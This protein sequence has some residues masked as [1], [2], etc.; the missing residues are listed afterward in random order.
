MSMLLEH[1]FPIGWKLFLREWVPALPGL[2]SWQSSQPQ[3]WGKF[4]G[5]K[6]KRHWGKHLTWNSA[7]CTELPYSCPKLRGARAKCYNIHRCL[8]SSSRTSQIYTHRR[9]VLSNLTPLND[10][11]G[12]EIQRDKWLAQGISPYCKR[13]LLCFWLLIY[14]MRLFTSPSSTM[15]ACIL[16][17]EL[18]LACSNSSRKFIILCPKLRVIAHVTCY[19]S[20][21]LIPYLWEYVVP[22]FR[23]LTFSKWTKLELPLWL[24]GLRTQHSICEGAGSNPGL[25][26]VG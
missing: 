3:P 4:Q 6:L 14:K 15:N 17:L 5:K 16:C 18:C 8:Y 1:L 11:F 22:Q 23:T 12:A 9:K 2:A 21:M 13:G 19:H 7:S 24:S 26:Q 20:A 10:K 25:T